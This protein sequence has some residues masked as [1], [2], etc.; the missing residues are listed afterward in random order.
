MVATGLRVGTESGLQ[1]DSILVRALSGA[2]TASGRVWGAPKD[3]PHQ[4]RL[5]ESQPM[6]LMS[7]MRSVSPVTTNL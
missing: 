3:A 4:I 5:L 6:S 7:S 1:A 2:L